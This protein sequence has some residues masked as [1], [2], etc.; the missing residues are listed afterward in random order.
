M[1]A[2]C[3]HF[4][5]VQSLDDLKH[6]YRR[7][8]LDNHPD[9]GGSKEEMQKIN[10]EYETLYEY[11]R[12]HIPEAVRPTA[13]AAESIRQFYTDNGWAGSRYDARLSTKDI[14]AR[15]REY[16]KTNWNQWKFSI[17]KHDASMC[18]EIRVELQG[19]PIEQAVLPDEDCKCSW[20]LQT[21]YRFG[22]DHN[23]RVAPEAEIVMRD[24]ISYVMS[25]NYDD[26]DGMIDY[27]DT[28][29]YL[30]ESIAGTEEWQFI[31]KRARLTTATSTASSDDASVPAKQSRTEVS[32]GIQVV[33]YSD[34]ALAVVG[35]TKPLK[36]RLK[37]LR[38][39]FNARLTVNGMQ[40]AGWI[41]SSSVYTVESLQ[42]AIFAA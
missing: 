24:V 39:R 13:T 3:S 19:G 7:L 1:T 29:F 8:V 38:G 15:V 37:E 33:V 2:T 36:E 14:A 27:F 18:S 20:R 31:Q 11:W 25:F 16:C 28:N 40:R 12:S 17:R 30:F 4:V 35:D 34:R 41:F 32:E 6:Q 21:S 22:R 42:Q 5:N 9:K 26:S 23:P 10:S